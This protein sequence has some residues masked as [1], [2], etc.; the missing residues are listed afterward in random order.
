V[1]AA[2][3]IWVVAAPAARIREA[4]DGRLHLTMIDVGQGDA[5]L[6]TFPNRRTLLIDSGGTSQQGEFDIGDRIVGPALRARNLLGIDY[7]CVTHGDPDHLGGATAVLRDFGAREVWWGVP[8]PSHAPT[9]ALRAEADRQR[10]P[11]RTL[12]RGDRLEIGGVEL[13]VH[14]PPLPDWERQR[15]RNDDSLVI[16]LRF[17]EVSLLLTGD[18][19]HEVE[20]ELSPR[21]DLLPL[22]VLKV[23]H[24]GSA[25][26]SSARFLDNA[27]PAVA[28]IG[29]GR[30][31]TYGHPV[32]S[33]LSRLAEIGAEVFRT[34]LDGQVEVVTDGQ[35]LAVE[36]FTG[37]RFRRP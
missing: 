21:L 2:L 15:V 28:L 25:T 36:T 8:V 6:V 7:L 4:D 18:V 12:Q 34:D 1:T 32:P 24:H 16:E 10:I 22:V 3:F 27:H 23:A 37:R 17:G 19:G 5:L 11:W 26:S 31:N 14:H 9:A 30:G 29:T 13:R 35:S 33:V 20:A